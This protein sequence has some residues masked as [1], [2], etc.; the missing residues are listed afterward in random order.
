MQ[1]EQIRFPIAVCETALEAVGSTH[2][3][4]EKRTNHRSAGRGNPVDVVPSQ[5]LDP[6][7]NRCSRKQQSLINRRNENSL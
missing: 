6:T 1:R 7:E 4:G 5:R 3:T 2:T